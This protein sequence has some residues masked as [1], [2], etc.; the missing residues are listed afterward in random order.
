MVKIGI[1]PSINNTGI[2]VWETDKDIN[3]YYMIP[4][5]MTKKM[6]LFNHNSIN[7]LPYTKREVKGLEY[8]EKEQFK[9]DNIYDICKLIGNILDLFNPEEIY[10]EGVSYGSVGSAALVDLCFLN[11]A[12]RS[13]IVRRNLKYT[14]VSPTSLKKFACANGQA[15]KN[16]IIDAWKRLDKNIKDVKDIKID[17][18]AD[19]FFLAHYEQTS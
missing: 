1:D 7:I 4:S 13:E 16:V 10:M 14:I 5:K 17:D 18:L 9:F 3:K 6:S 19:S 8:S 12:I 2:C 15:E 11:A